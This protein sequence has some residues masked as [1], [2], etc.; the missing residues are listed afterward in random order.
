MEG[1]LVTYQSYGIKVHCDMVCI[2]CLS[3]HFNYHVAIWQHEAFSFMMSLPAMSFGDGIIPKLCNRAL[4][5]YIK[6]EGLP[7]IKMH[8]G[9]LF[10]TDITL[11]HFKE[12]LH[13]L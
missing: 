5:I 11:R 13:N 10:I 4:Q 12:I 1:L 2:W 6:K 9:L 8:A 7:C 3:Q